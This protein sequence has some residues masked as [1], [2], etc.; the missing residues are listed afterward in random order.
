MV[1]FFLN[2]FL[3]IRFFIDIYSNVKAPLY[4]WSVEQTIGVRWKL[5]RFKI[6][7]DCNAWNSIRNTFLSI[8]CLLRSVHLEYAVTK[9]VELNVNICRA[10]VY[11]YTMY[12]QIADILI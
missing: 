4:V 11:D 7:S 3:K 8:N 12:K 5:F 1:N 9:E 6:S 2:F 10:S